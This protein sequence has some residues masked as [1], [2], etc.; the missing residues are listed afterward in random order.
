M[1]QETIKQDT[2]DQID[3]LLNQEEAIKEEKI[4]A[5]Q[6]ETDTQ[7]ETDETEEAPVAAE[8]EDESVAEAEP[9]TDAGTEADAEA[10]DELP[11]ETV[12]DV[13]GLDPTM[14]DVDENGQVLV[15]TKVDGEEKLVKPSELIKSFQLEQ[16]VHKKSEEVS[17][18]KRQ[19]QQTLEQWGQQLAEAQQLLQQAYAQLQNEAQTVD[20]ETLR[21]ED[22]AEYAAKKAELLEREQRLQQQ[23]A[24]FQQQLVQYQQAQAQQQAE[25]MGQEAQRVIDE[26]PEWRDES[27]RKQEAAAIMNWLKEQGWTDTELATIVTAPQIKALRLAWKAATGQQK[28]AEMR[29]KVRPQKGTRT[30][31][32]GRAVTAADRNRKAIAQKVAKAR[33]SG[34]VSA[35]ADVLTDV[36]E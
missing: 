25:F 20:W 7:A 14:L 31:K 27:T 1:A 4:D 10:V 15:R 19:A 12:A 6:P 24:Q 13:L 26:I 29:K 2:L 8:Q 28:V 23:A 36:I 16:H 21:E 30:L 5:Q 17:Q 22:P 32:P 35:W 11:L 3:A 9:E 18:A 33:K 34:D